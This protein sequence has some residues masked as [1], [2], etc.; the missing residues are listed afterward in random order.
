MKQILDGR[1][2]CRRIKGLGA[3]SAL[4]LALLLAACTTRAPAPAADP[5]ADPR[6]A[7]EAAGPTLAAAGSSGTASRHMVAAANPHA[8]EA[9]REMLRAGGT[10]VDAAIAAQMVL[11]LVEPQSSGLGGG[12]FLLHYDAGDSAVSAFDGRE[13]APAAATEALFLKDDGTPMGFWD[14]VVGGRSV[15]VPGVL[16]MLRLAHEA[17]G[18][19]PWA[20]LMEPAIELAETGF[21][22][23]PR[24]H[25][26][27]SRDRFLGSQEAARAYFFGPDGAPKPV[28]TILRNPALADSLRRI[29]W[30]GAEAFYEGEIAADIVAA[31]QGVAGNP[32]QMSLEDLRGYRA[33]EREPLCRPYRAWQVCGVPPP[34]SG[35]VA[36][37][38]MLG[39]LEAF[40][41]A[42]LAPN[43]AEAAHLIAEAGR[44]AF[45]DR[46]LFL[47]DSDF[48]P[49]PVE[50]LLDRGYLRER[51]GL[52]APGTS[53][54]KAAPGLPAETAAM[55]RQDDPPSTSHLAVVD[56]AGNAVSMTSSI[57]SAFG[58]RQMVRGFLLNNE[59]TD[60]SFRPEADGRP[61]ANRVQPGK[62]PRSSMSPL[63]VLDEDGKLLLAIGSPGG[64]RIIGYVLRATLGV[65]DWG[66][67]P[68]SA[69]ELPHVVN[70][71]GAT[72]LE[73][74]S[75][76]QGAAPG[77]LARGHQINYR[78]MTSGL[79]AI[80]VTPDGLR[81]GADPR[82]EGVALGD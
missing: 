8:A 46:G 42:P 36:V 63:L 68:Q 56:A 69:V 1:R 33:V 10:A 34:T 3:A 76:I 79:H 48:V 70:R 11:T 45:A 43:G 75:A 59:L 28:G 82:R 22:I 27:V 52:I 13:T 9:G 54:G 62:R 66:L 6:A 73:F 58:S 47:A 44:L 65:L 38:Q 60:F 67:D 15:G 81:G 64:S 12:A 51:A 7:P 71:N 2:P 39:V 31:V 49:V 40:E 16:R 35:G 20:F 24:L 41:L 30:G 21:A 37:L 78:D 17:H 19:L 4:G 29:A 61:V 26:L 32:G 57:E 14:A 80:Q 72:D 77:L 18:R 5:L 53:M 50:R 23:S 25:S 74:G 55:P